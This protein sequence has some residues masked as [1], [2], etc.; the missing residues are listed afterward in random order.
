MIIL[1]TFALGPHE[2]VAVK[3]FTLPRTLVGLE[4]STSACFDVAFAF[5]I[6]VV[7]NTANIVRPLLYFKNY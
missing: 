3:N 1:I 6:A 5:V 2:G 7:A 4:A